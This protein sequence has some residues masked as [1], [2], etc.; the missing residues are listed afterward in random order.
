[1]SFLSA[2]VERRHGF[3]RCAH[4]NDNM[5][6]ESGVRVKNRCHTE[7]SEISQTGVLLP[8]FGWGLYQHSPV[9]NRGNDSIRIQ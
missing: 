4:Q 1:L 3:F 6:C 5:G 8:P 2:V 7:R 9:N